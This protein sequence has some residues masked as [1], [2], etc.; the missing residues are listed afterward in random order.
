MNVSAWFQGGDDLANLRVTGIRTR[1][2]QHQIYIGEFAA[3]DL[4]C[5]VSAADAHRI[6]QAWL[7]VAATLADTEAT[8]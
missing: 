6:A 5:Y 8:P 3:A 2:G 7:T 1:D 4:H